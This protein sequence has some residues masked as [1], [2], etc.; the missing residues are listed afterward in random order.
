MNIYKEKI[1]IAGSGGQ[2]I[3]FIGK[4]LYLTAV[5]NGLEATFF[6]SYGA[7]VRGGSTKCMVI[8][9]REKIP[10]P[11]FRVPDTAIILNAVSFR[12]YRDVLR[13]CPRIILYQKNGEK[14]RALKKGQNVYSFSSLH[15]AHFEN[16]RSAAVYSH[17]ADW[18]SKEDFLL[19]L[20]HILR[21]KAP[22][23]IEK[24]K[25]VFDEAYN[26]FQVKV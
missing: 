6:P 21:A 15:G 14:V 18:F 4:A 12:R 17:I 2:G 22:Q 5:G 24:N 16:V 10:M 13:D 11:V 7:E 9:S 20:A 1:F 23:L 3:L 25:D 19:A 8:V 26:G